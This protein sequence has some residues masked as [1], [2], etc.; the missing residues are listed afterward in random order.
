MEE[1]FLSKNKKGLKV[2]TGILS[3]NV[4]FENM[5]HGYYNNT[6]LKKVIFLYRLEVAKAC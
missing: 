3:S 6:F 4:A 5:N 1:S 2:G